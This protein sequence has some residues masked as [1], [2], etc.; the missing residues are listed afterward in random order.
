MN[1]LAHTARYKKSPP[2]RELNRQQPSCSTRAAFARRSI[3]R[4]GSLGA[5]SATATCELGAFLRYNPRTES[6]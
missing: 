6:L 4:G 5:A 1:H 3:A 2:S